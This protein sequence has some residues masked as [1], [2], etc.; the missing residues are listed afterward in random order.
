MNDYESLKESPLL[1]SEVREKVIRSEQG[2][3]GLQETYQRIQNDPDLTTEAKARL[4]QEAFEKNQAS[5]VE[6]NI[7]AREALIKTAKSK[8]KAAV[9]T[10]KG[11]TLTTDDPTRLLLIQGEA[12]R[13]RRI[14]EKRG[15]HP[16]GGG[17][18]VGDYL[19]S[20]YAR[21]VNELSGAE[22]QAVAAGTLRAAVELGVSEEEIVSPLRTDQQREL[23]DEARRLEY[24]SGMFSKEAPTPP[25]ELQ[26]QVAQNRRREM[27]QRTRVFMPESE[28]TELQT[29]TEPSHSSGRK[30]KPSWK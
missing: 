3:R 17:G 7:A 25:K 22:A 18:R 5:V 12:E 9:P 4:A 27:V 24:M 21:A 20:E 14:A 2:R 19:K 28:P 29:A 11:V 23:L 26:K 30:R 10:P 15:D 16:L 13:I 6:K 1:T 8:E